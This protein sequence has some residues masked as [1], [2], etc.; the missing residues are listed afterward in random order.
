MPHNQASHCQER[1]GT[2]YLYLIT[3]PSWFWGNRWR[4]RESVSVKWAGLKTERLATDWKDWLR[5]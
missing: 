3:M 4:S 5:G 2:L 1:L